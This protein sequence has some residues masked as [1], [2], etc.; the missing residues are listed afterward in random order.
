MG[1]SSRG[2][3]SCN[4]LSISA[5]AEPNNVLSWEIGSSKHRRSQGREEG[6]GWPEAPPPNTHTHDFS[7]MQSQQR[8]TEGPGV[9]AGQ[10][11]WEVPVT[12]SQHPGP[13]SLPSEGCDL[14]PYNNT[15]SVLI[16]I[17]NAQQLELS[18]SWVQVWLFLLLC[19]V[20]SPLCLSANAG[21][22]MF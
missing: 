12:P 10:S 3:W 5:T 8:R 20:T 14:G 22:V 18:D 17:E 13:R 19:H 21:I 11:P 4:P 6:A 15:L 2:S 7:K 16:T 1:R 9:E